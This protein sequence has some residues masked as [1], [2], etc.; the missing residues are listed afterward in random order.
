MT[1]E[2]FTP[3]DVAITLNWDVPAGVPAG[4]P[5]EP[6]LPQPAASRAARPSSANTG[7]RR[8]RASI[9]K[10]NT[11]MSES[12]SGRA[13]LCKTTG[14]SNLVPMGAAN[15]RTAVLTV[16]VTVAGDAATVTGLGENEQEAPAGRPLQLSATCCE[17]R[18]SGEIVKWKPAACPAETVALDG[19]AETVKSGPWAKPVPVSRTTCGLPDPLSVRVRAPM[20]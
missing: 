7:R 2:C 16:T 11:R 5:A 1:V 14:K 15:A 10:L 4:T 19:V 9:V 13:T 3:P 17:N 8:S 20:L 18:A 12:Q 6:P